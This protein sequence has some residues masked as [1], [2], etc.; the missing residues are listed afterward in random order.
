VADLARQGRAWLPVI[1]AA[2]LFVLPTPL[3]FAA[4][5]DL[6]SGDLGRLALTGTGLLSFWGAGTVMWRA[7]VAEARYCLGQRPDPP[8]FPLK[9]ASLALTVLGTGLAGLAGGQNL[10]VAIVFALLAGFGHA[11]FYG[12]DLRPR[13]VSV[14]RVDGIDIAA[15]TAQLKQAYGR[16]R[17]IDA[18]AR[19]IAVSE[20]GERLTRIT[21]IGRDIL[22]EIERDPRDAARARR[23][24]NLYLD[25]AEKV[26]RQYAQTHRQLRSRPLEQNF[27]QLLVDMEQNFADQHKKLLENDELALDVDIEVLNARLKRDGIH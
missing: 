3:F 17:G 24:L 27:R 15:V 11:A 19:N 4:L 18:A 21:D 26:T 9:A 16:L 25:S 13:N 14:V 8:A 10:T 5:I 23:F 22:A 20:F 1:K 12:P 6:I 7:L 2:A